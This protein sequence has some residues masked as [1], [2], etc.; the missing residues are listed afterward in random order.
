MP[1]SPY[2]KKIPHFLADFKETQYV[3]IMLIIYREFAL[4]F[5]LSRVRST[6]FNGLNKLLCKLYIL[7]PLSD[8]D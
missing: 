4:C 5:V 6:V 3:R 2:G 8:L 7:S 1:I